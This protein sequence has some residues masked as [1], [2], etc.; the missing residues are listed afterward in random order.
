M[1]GLYRPSRR[2]S[3]LFQ[4]VILLQ[5]RSKTL[6]PLKLMYLECSQQETFSVMTRSLLTEHWLG[7]LLSKIT[8][9]H[10]AVLLQ[11]ENVSYCLAVVRS[12]VAR[13][14]RRRLSLPF[15]LR[16]VVGPSWPSHNPHYLLVIGTFPMPSGRYVNY[17]THPLKFSLICRLTA[18]YE[19]DSRQAFDFNT[20]I[21]HT[22]NI[23]QTLGIDIF[24]DVCYDAWVLRTLVGRI[25]ENVSRGPLTEGYNS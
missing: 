16:S 9:R 22:T 21:V 1:R 8:A 5:A 4:H 10:V 25:S 20:D 14:V 11:V 6:G 12:T 2:H 15:T 13:S 24:A 17:G 7:S 23:L 3:R 18:Q 19:G